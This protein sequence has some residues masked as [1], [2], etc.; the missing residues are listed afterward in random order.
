MRSPER[1]FL[2]ACL[3]VCA[4]VSSARPSAINDLNMLLTDYRSLSLNFQ[5][6]LFDPS[7]RVL[8][9]VFG[10]ASV[11]RPHQL[12]WE[13]LKPYSQLIV[14]DGKVIWLYDP[15]LL[16]ATRRPFEYNP[17][18]SIALLLLGGIDNTADTFEVKR[19][20]S[21]KNYQIFTLF[22]INK[23]SYFDSLEVTFRNRKIDQLVLTNH[24][25]QTTVFTFSRVKINPQLKPASFRFVPPD[26]IEVND[27][28]G[29]W[30]Q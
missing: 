11:I 13:V 27:E 28:T 12:R 25:D 22:P 19:Q 24:N 8:E 6:T 2:C 30:V 9:R 15:D 26:N 16:Q 4:A 20:P 5:Q 10:K 18:E 1:L 17:D 23:V 3:L 7:G 29:D 14:S 21:G